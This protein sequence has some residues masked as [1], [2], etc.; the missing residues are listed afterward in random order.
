[1]KSDPLRNAQAEGGEGYAW[2]SLFCSR[3]LPRPYP[4]GSD[5]DTPFP[6]VD[7]VSGRLK[8]I[9]LLYQVDSLN[10]CV[11]NAFLMAMPICSIVKGFCT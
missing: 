8:R 7:G 5:P 1:M 11:S 9:E 10:H 6:P 3:I 4:L 2:A